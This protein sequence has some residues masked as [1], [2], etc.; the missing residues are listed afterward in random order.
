MEPPIQ[1]GPGSEPA[2]RS[3]PQDAGK[4]RLDRAFGGGRIIT[5]Y[6]YKGGTGRSMA[7][8][9]AAWA[10]AMAGKRV[11]VMDWDL[12]APG[13][14][15]Y[16]H[17]FLKDPNLESTDGVLEYLTRMARTAAA[18][19]VDTDWRNVD[20]DFFEELAAPDSFVQTLEFQDFPGEAGIK[21]IGAGRQD[22]SYSERLSLFN[23]VQFYEKLGGRRFVDALRK[24]LSFSY[25]YVLVD[26]RTGVSDTSGI[27]TIQMP[28]TLVVCFTLNE[29]SIRGASGIASD[30]AAKRAKDDA[31]IP[32]RIFPVPTRIE[33]SEHERRLIAME[34]VKKVFNAF[35]V[36]LDETRKEEYWGQMQVVY[37]PYYAFEEI[38]AMFGN[39]ATEAISMSAATNSILRYVTGGEVGTP[40]VLNERKRRAYLEK[41]V[42]AADD[43]L[44]LA[45]QVVEKNPSQLEVIRRLLLRF[46]VSGGGSK[47]DATRPLSLDDCQADEMPF[48]RE[49]VNDGL[50]QEDS[51]QSPP[52]LRLAHEDLPRRWK[53]LSDWI[54]ADRE[55][56][57]WRNSV[58]S[59]A[60][61]WQSS[62]RSPS[63]LLRDEQLR[64]AMRW[65]RER[66]DS[67]SPDT[68]AFLRES[69]RND[70]SA[71]AENF[72]KALPEPL[73]PSVFF[74]QFVTAGGARRFVDAE[75]VYPNAEVVRQAI[76][77]GVV[78]EV[79]SGPFMKI[80]GGPGYMLVSDDLV[81]RWPPLKRWLEEN[82]A[83][84]AARDE[85]ELLARGWAEEQRSPRRLL[86]GE[87][88][89]RLA[90]PL[91]GRDE[92]ELPPLVRDFLAESEK[93]DPILRAEAFV[94]SCPPQRVSALERFALRFVNVGADSLPQAVSV[95]VSDPDAE[96]EA[97]VRLALSAS[98]VSAVPAGYT[99]VEPK[100]ISNWDWYLKLIERERDFLLLRTRLEVQA[101][102][103]SALG[104]KGYPLS[105]S[106]YRA[107]TKA[108]ASRPTEGSGLLRKHVRNYVEI[109]RKRAR[110]RTQVAVVGL[111]VIL[112]A[113]W[114]GFWHRDP[115]SAIDPALDRDQRALLIANA[116]RQGQ[117]QRD[118]MDQKLAQSVR[119][120]R[121]LGVIAGSGTPSQRGWQF[122][123]SENDSVIAWSQERIDV[124]DNKPGK[125]LPAF[126]KRTI[127]LGA[128][129]CAY[130]TS[131]AT[132]ACSRKPGLLEFFDFG[133]LK[134][135]QLPIQSRGNGTVL[136]FSPDGKFWALGDDE[137]TVVYGPNPGNPA[138]SNLKYSSYGAHGKSIKA[139]DWAD[140]NLHFATAAGTVTA[141]IWNAQ[142][143]R[144]RLDL[145]A[146][147]STVDDVKFAP[148]AGFSPVLAA[149][150][151][152][153]AW[154]WNDVLRMSRKIQPYECRAY[155][156]AVRGRS[157]FAASVS[158]I[159]CMPSFHDAKDGVMLWNA[160]D[161]AY[162]GTVGASSQVQS[163]AF[164]PNEKLLVI[165]D[166]VLDA[167]L[168]GGE[169]T[170][171]PMSILPSGVGSTAAFSADS[172]YLATANANGTYRVWLVDLSG[173]QAG[174][175][176]DAANLRQAICMTVVCR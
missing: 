38:P 96:E 103:W 52:V 147:D 118:T 80:A 78:Y 66:G 126:S 93:G 40:A 8:A 64:N 30:V 9:N 76:E 60:A 121:Y 75:D 155:Q 170:H 10:L 128:S 133:S 122:A 112:L 11:L 94:Q 26:S 127:D 137:G 67:L 149:A 85:L 82:A 156:V 68:R 130:G 39:P 72:A 176:Y 144:F 54:E 110:L 70:P 91:K 95:H 27:C 69:E 135:T 35:L 107:W 154:I 59:A 139:L 86:R 166:S 171:Q 36:D 29:Q 136:K 46:V 14:H 57:T 108:T 132:L 158:D 24:L 113:A 111:V 131:S 73:V 71:A 169:K 150:G 62:G 23:F 2:S 123:F 7:L 83:V 119:D 172:K 33:L 161:G 124:F 32:F 19:P 61:S 168:Q 58:D 41:F 174:S 43:P 92:T 28:D 87:Q 148:Q 74:L 34:R 114:V 115:L 42:R 4:E 13:V 56:L 146:G 175:P 65:E 20:D 143:E 81:Y 106:D 165:G 45:R 167:N 102:L 163:L 49:F 12:E 99:L 151:S 17:P 77:M 63:A 104:E 164:S 97:L 105:T 162:V 138:T 159:N 142:V 160:G 18:Q 89:E 37:I 125:V 116:I 53:L 31:V 98:L 5:F 90:A 173:F 50:L 44:L 6:S 117:V 129:A 157:E 141:V 100:L 15:R 25:D 51:D 55:F 134:I 1:P 16:F 153:G 88:L 101:K 3:V 47:P 84:V 79:T 22:A 140:D 48:V 21:F 120:L 152:G 109:A 145:S